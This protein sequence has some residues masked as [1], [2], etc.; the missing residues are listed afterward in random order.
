MRDNAKEDAKDAALIDLAN[1]L[2][3][4][5]LIQS[6]FEIAPPNEFAQRLHRVVALGLDVDPAAKADV[7]V[8]APE[9]EEAEEAPA[10]AEEE[11]HDEL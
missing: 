6:G 9:A 7:E 3:D 1:L 10:A 8:E 2:Y 5:A 4:A 11:A